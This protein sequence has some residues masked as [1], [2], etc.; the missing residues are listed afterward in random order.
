MPHIPKC[1]INQKELIY[2]SVIQRT[3]N[4]RFGASF[5]WLHF[6]IIHIEKALRTRYL[7]EA[8]TYVRRTG[9]L[10]NNF[11]HVCAGFPNWACVGFYT[12]FYHLVSLVFFYPQVIDH[13]I[14]HESAFSFKN[15]EGFYSE[16]WSSRSEVS[17]SIGKV[18]G[19]HDLLVF[20]LD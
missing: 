17:N 20:P 5:S 19:L 2:T 12:S 1:Y 18:Q 13:D 16:G 8:L 3:D 14:F 10:C 9:S 11:I 7:S 15:W 4:K 6:L